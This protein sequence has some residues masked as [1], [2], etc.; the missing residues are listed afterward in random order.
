MN[1]IGA[2][3]VIHNLNPDLGKD[4]SF[5]IYVS[6]LFNTLPRINQNSVTLNSFHPQ[7]T[8]CS[9]RRFVEQTKTQQCGGINGF[10]SWAK[11]I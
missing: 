10:I 6:N 3:V 4:A 5:T 7:N 8:L 2:L 9:H 11:L 1:G